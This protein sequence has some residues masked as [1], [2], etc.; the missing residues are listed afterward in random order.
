[1]YPS[2][3]FLIRGNHEFRDVNSYMEMNGFEVKLALAFGPD[4]ASELFETVHQCFDWLP[5]ACVVEEKILVLHGGI[6]AGEWSIAELERVQRP[7][8]E[9]E[10]ADEDAE[11]EVA[12][13]CQM[14]LEALWSDPS[15]SDADM[16]RGVHWGNRGSENIPEFG[17]GKNAGGSYSRTSTPPLTLTVHR[18]D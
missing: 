16:R 8:R 2:R 10:L 6:G 3:V 9:L 18:C 11:P 12:R 14:V 17:P 1:M 13:A 4:I 15:D 7:I 5:L